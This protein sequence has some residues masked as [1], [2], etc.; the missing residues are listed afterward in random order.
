MGEATAAAADVEDA[1]A[2]DDGESEVDEDLVA[3]QLGSRE[4]QIPMPRSIL[5]VEGVG[6]HG[7]PEATRSVD[8]AAS[9]VTE[10][11]SGENDHSSRKNS[12]SEEVNA[13]VNSCERTAWDHGGVEATWEA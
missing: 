1:R 7:M 12:S 10:N 6:W 11:F 3:R 2:R 13:R 5:A 8:E 4:E 9:Q